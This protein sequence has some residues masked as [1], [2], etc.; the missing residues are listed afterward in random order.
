M[1]P[2]GD[3]PGRKASPGTFYRKT[4]PNKRTPALS[5]IE[6][7][8]GVVQ[9]SYHLHEL[10]H[11]CKRWKAIIESMPEFCS[12]M[13]IFIGSNATPFMRIETQILKSANCLLDVTVRSR[14]K[15]NREQEMKRARAVMMLLTPIITRC[16]TFV[17]D[18][19]HSSSLPVI[20]KDFRGNAEH[21]RVLKLECEVDDGARTPFYGVPEIPE[22]EEFKC[23]S[24]TTLAMDGITFMDACFVS[25]TKQFK[26]T[27]LDSLSIYGLSPQLIDDD[28]YEFNN[29]AFCGGLAEIGFIRHLTLDN[30]DILSDGV[31]QDQEHTWDNLTLIGNH[32][33][34][35]EDFLAI[36]E[37]DTPYCCYHLSDC[38]FD[39]SCSPAAH[40]L[41]LENITN[42]HRGTFVRA[43][44]LHRGSVLD[45]IDC[46][47]LDDVNLEQIMRN[48]ANLRRLS[49]I[50]CPRITIDGL[51]NMVKVRNKLVENIHETSNDPRDY[52][53]SNIY[54]AERYDGEVNAHLQPRPLYKKIDR[55]LVENCCRSLTLSK[56]DQSW[57]KTHVR[58]F[59]WN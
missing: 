36:T 2:L 19:R 42:V 34:M 52:G 35:V 21:L 32:P 41:R 24:L 53:R 16:R 9:F 46:K 29:M 54:Y 11:V 55:L 12:R 23:P 40:H 26:S 48:C 31:V 14:G 45:I 22:G 4:E 5:H 13:L 25:W 58:H 57:F 49:L 7:S 6:K 1:A 3:T 50:D 51:K 20:S 10:R 15:V 38:D 37:S 27:Y 33:R 39:Y 44:T 30:L 17:F 43:L 28:T 47:E 18:V 59:S 56:A 8:R